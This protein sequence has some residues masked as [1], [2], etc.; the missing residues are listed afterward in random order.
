ML[1]VC[2]FDRFDGR[3]GCCRVLGWQRFEG[4]LWSA[5]GGVLT[6]LMTCAAVLDL[7]EWVFE[8]VWVPV[9]G[10]CVVDRVLALKSSLL[11]ENVVDFGCG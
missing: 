11:K 6:I 3:G 2:A 1:V 10:N 9:D 5:L 8:V 7:I 4:L